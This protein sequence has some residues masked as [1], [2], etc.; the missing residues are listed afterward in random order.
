[1]LNPPIPIVSIYMSVNVCSL[2][3]TNI[4]DAGLLIFRC[5]AFSSLVV[6]RLPRMVIRG[7]IIP[8]TAAYNRPPDI[9][10]QRYHSGCSAA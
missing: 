6:L 1:M 8:D 10:P 9:G 5:F 7:P 3:K 2:C 4:T